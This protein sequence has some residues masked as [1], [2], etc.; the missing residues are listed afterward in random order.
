MCKGEGKAILV[1]LTT[2]TKFIKAKAASCTFQIQC[3]QGALMNKEQLLPQLLLS[4][5]N[6]ETFQNH[7]YTSYTAK[8]FTGHL[9]I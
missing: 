8:D 3:K 7:L 6:V 1:L 4:L 5:N 2:K 9:R